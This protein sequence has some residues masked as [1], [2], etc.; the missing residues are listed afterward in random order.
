MRTKRKFTLADCIATAKS[1]NGK[2]LSEEFVNVNTKMLW[3]C[4]KGHQWESTYKS[5][6]ALESWCPACIG[7]DK[8]VQFA[9]LQNTLVTKGWTILSGEYEGTKKRTLLIRC[10]EGHEWTTSHQ[11]IEL[12][13]CPECSQRCRDINKNKLAIEAII[14]SKK[15]EWVSG[16][17]KNA[18]SR[19]TVK[20]QFG[21]SW[22]TT[23]VQIKNHGGWCP[24]CQG[25]NK[26]EQLKIIKEISK[27]N[28]G[29]CLSTRYVNKDKKLKFKCVN[30]HEFKMA[31][32]NV[33][34]GQ[35]CPKCS[36]YQMENKTRYTF[37]KLTGVLFEKNGKR[38][39]SFELDGY[40]NFSE[41]K[42]EIAFE[43]N[44]IQHYKFVK[45]FHKTIEGFLKRQ[46][47]DK[48]KRKACLKEGILLL[49]VPYYCTTT[50]EELLL[51]VLELLYCCGVNATLVESVEDFYEDFYSKSPQIQRVKK[52]IKAKGGT[53]LSRAYNGS[54]TPITIICKEGHEWTTQYVCITQGKWCPN[55]AGRSR[56]KDW[57]FQQLKKRVEDELGFNLITPHYTPDREK[58]ELKC[59]S[60][61]LFKR[62]VNHLK[63]RNEKCPFC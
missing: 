60:G 56:D 27:K 34:N 47:A 20:C 2:C 49:E 13:G 17:Y 32:S 55:C 51:Y 12:Y 9:K 7:R 50:D 21:H 11:K 26:E 40:H 16:E 6:E 4:H 43:Y 48:D 25:H 15:G 28:G 10:D 1:R 14:A 36:Y 46:E 61:H 5:V 39:A 45:F 23:P 38:I 62:T 54:Q 30:G 8:D 33:K 29:E 44:G 3:E 35:W 31:P 24:T 63:R 19:I 41:L 22:D 57:L 58:V 59:P 52:I 37:E 18:R 53:L 42:L